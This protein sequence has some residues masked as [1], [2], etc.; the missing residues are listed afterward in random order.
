[1]HS[2]E[3]SP[4]DMLERICENQLALEAAIME[5]S[6]WTVNHGG[7]H[8]DENVRGSLASIGENL[9]HIKQALAKLKARGQ[10]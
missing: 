5:L 7:L 2:P 10:Q 3:Y 8:V 6:L 1:M 9:G 4:T